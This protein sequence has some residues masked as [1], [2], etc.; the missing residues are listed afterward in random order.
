MCY[1]T[2]AIVK[3][4]QHTATLMPFPNDSI[5]LMWLHNIT[6][7][8]LQTPQG[9]VIIRLQNVV[10]TGSSS[11]SSLL[12]YH[13]VMPSKG[14]TQLCAKLCGSMVKKKHFSFIFN[15]PFPSGSRKA[16]LS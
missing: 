16:L 13:C 11:P 1:S 5:I 14:W 12:Q 4:A 9:I 8:A 3:G 15:P 6:A 7:A 2:G 10:I